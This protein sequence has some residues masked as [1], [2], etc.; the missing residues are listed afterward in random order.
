[1]K[2][3]MNQ[4]KKEFDTYGEEDHAR[5]TLQHSTQITDLI[6][7]MESFID[8]AVNSE[9]GEEFLNTM[10]GMDSGSC[11]AGEFAFGTNYGINRFTNN[12][13]YDEK[14]G[15]TIHIALGAAYP[16]TGSKNESGLHWDMLC[17]MREGGEVYADGELVYK[18]GKFIF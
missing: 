4:T 10:I 12:M 13:L 3:S 6:G 9:Q 2:T 14:I 8:S 1:L 17:N 7:L 15:G 18:N 5:K 11:Y 16:S